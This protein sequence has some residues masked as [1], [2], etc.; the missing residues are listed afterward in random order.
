MESKTNAAGLC[1]SCFSSATWRFWQKN[2]SWRKKDLTN[3]RPYCFMMFKHK[4]F[5]FLGFESHSGDVK[6][7]HTSYFNWRYVLLMM[8]AQKRRSILKGFR[9]FTDNVQSIGS[10]LK[11]YTPKLLRQHLQ[12]RRFSPPVICF[13]TLDCLTKVNFSVYG[14]IFSDKTDII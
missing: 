7:V 10:A 3:D 8:N 2:W 1:K 9:T 4:C 12:H 11:S 5:W 13:R 6:A 14:A